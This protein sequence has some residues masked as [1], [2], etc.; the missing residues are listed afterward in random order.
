[1]TAPR[2]N[3][4][5]SQLEIN[6]EAVA[7]II[8]SLALECHDFALASGIPSGSVDLQLPGVLDVFSD[9]SHHLI[10]CR[11]VVTESAPCIANITLGLSN[12][13]YRLMAQAAK[14]R[15]AHVADGD[16]NV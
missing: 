16:A 15:V 4:D 14:D 13:G 11:A 6:D 12:V 9:L 3:L 10:D 7:L 1:M 8:N 2:L 5:V